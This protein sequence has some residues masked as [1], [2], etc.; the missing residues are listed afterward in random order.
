MSS[1]SRHLLAGS[2]SCAHLCVLSSQGQ[3]SQG[4]LCTGWAGPASPHPH[5][6]RSLQT[7]LGSA[8]QMPGGDGGRGYPRGRMRPLQ[9]LGAKSAQEA[10][11]PTMSRTDTHSGRRI[12]RAGQPLRLRSHPQSP[13]RTALSPPSKKSWS[14]R[15]HT[16]GNFRAVPGEVWTPTERRASAHRPCSDFSPFTKQ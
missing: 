5:G 9:T 2:V 10:G 13:G 16:Q 3:D 8:Q 14:G 11:L 15:C 7:R 4:V 12:P 6:S 1:S